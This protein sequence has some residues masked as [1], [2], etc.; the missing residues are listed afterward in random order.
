MF[1]TK[2]IV[3]GKSSTKHKYEIYWE[4]EI[5][6]LPVLQETLLI[7]EGYGILLK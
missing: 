7:I 1:P 5:K 3:S 4:E 6:E 2:T